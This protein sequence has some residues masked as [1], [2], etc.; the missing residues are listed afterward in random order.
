MRKVIVCKSQATVAAER[1][2]LCRIARR[3]DSTGRALAAAWRASTQSCTRETIVAVT[4]AR[5]QTAFRRCAVA[6]R[7]RHCAPICRTTKANIVKHFEPTA[8]G[9]QSDR[10]IVSRQSTVHGRRPLRETT[11]D[12]EQRSSASRVS[13]RLETA[14]TPTWIC[15]SAI[16]ARHRICSPPFGGS[17]LRPLRHTIVSSAFALPPLL[18]H[19]TLGFQLALTHSKSQ[20][21][22]CR[23][24]VEQTNATRLLAT[25]LLAVVAAK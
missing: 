15:F 17:Q 9:C 23:L 5:S 12:N 6:R 19:L 16:A 8:I 2:A 18:A 13:C 14:N 4:R 24:V 7:A 21:T 11:L 25:L 22:L 20:T 1:R 3:R 10:S